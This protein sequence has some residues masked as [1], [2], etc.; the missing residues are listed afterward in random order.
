MNGLADE[1]KSDRKLNEQRYRTLNHRHEQ[2]ASEAREDRSRG[3]ATVEATHQA[4]M[5]LMA[6]MGRIE[7]HLKIAE[8]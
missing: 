8:E 1:M 6:S 3:L 5:G 7:K 4:I 2:L